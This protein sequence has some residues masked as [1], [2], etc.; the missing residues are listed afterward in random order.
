MGTEDRA[1]GVVPHDVTIGK[2][3]GK[4]SKLNQ[5][6]S[7][8]K[9]AGRNEHGLRLDENGDGV[10]SQQLFGA[11]PLGMNLE[12]SMQQQGSG[13]PTLLSALKGS[14]LRAAYGQEFG[15][16]FKEDD[17]GLLGD[18]TRFDGVRR[19]GALRVR[20]AFYERLRWIRRRVRKERPEAGNKKSCDALTHGCSR[21]A[22][23]LSLLS[24]SRCSTLERSKREPGALAG[25]GPNVGIDDCSARNRTAGYA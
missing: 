18:F 25:K 5:R 23:C 22:L 17:M 11:D 9:D 15:S 4:R 14:S 8:A 21:G 10:V 19:R 3:K 13:S 6:K 16:S 7:T 1:A 20:E 2:A 12:D 24:S